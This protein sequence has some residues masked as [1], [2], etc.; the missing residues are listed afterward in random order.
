MISFENDYSE[1]AS[2]KILQR[3]IETNMEQLSGY[4]NDRYCESAKEK[5]RKACG[6]PEAEIYFL[7]GGTQTNRIV[8]SSMLQPYEGVIAA[9]TGH[10]SSHEAGAIES[11][12][13]K[14][15]TLPQHDGKIEPEE[16][17]DYL[18][19]FYGD[20]NHE[21]MV[22]PLS[23]ERFIQKGSWR[24]WQIS[25]W[26]TIFHFIWMVQDWDMPWRQIRM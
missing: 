1:G 9:Q 17:A 24:S 18:N 12:G 20:G 2:E 16:L 8:I 13:H 14:V 11:S 6:C 10:V 7:S 21:H 5:I 4:G 3:L 26:N 23:M 25:A 22:F 15:L 19:D